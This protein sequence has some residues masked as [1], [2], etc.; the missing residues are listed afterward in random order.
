[1][2]TR[3][4]IRRSSWLYKLRTRV[5]TRKIIP[6][7]LVVAGVGFL[8]IAGTVLWW[9]RD[10]PDPQKIEESRLEESTKIY[11]STGTH[12]LYEIGEAKRTF[13]S[14]EELSPLLAQATLAAE[15]DQFYEHHGLD[16]LGIIRGVIL[17]PLSGQRAQGGSTITQQLI[18]NSILT[19]ERTI[20]RKAKEAVLAIELEQRFE[21]DEI[22]EMYLN[23]IPY[24]SR[25]YGAE[26][27]A[28]TFFG[29]SARNLS[30]AQATTL[31][32]LPQAPSYYSPYGSHLEDMKARQEHI[33]SRMASL[34]MVTQAEAD[35][36]K[37]EELAFLPAAENITA[38]H[39]VFYVKEQLERE[40][41][42]RVVEQGGLKVLTTLDFR[43]Q[44]IAEETLKAEQESL[45][46]RGAS[47][48]SLVAIH[49]ST[50]DILA[51][52]GSIDYFNE[53]IDGNVN[54]SIRHRSPGSSIKP[55]IYTAAFDKGY[56]P[57]TILVDAVTDFGQGYTPKNYDLS[58]RGP[59]TMRTALSN[60]LNIPAVK[61][62]YLAGVKDATELAQKMGMESLNDPDRYGLSLVLGGGEV[63]LL[64]ITSAYGVFA[65]EGVRHPARAI[66][67]VEDD[68]QAVFDATEEPPKGTQV[69]SEQVSRITTD[70]IS[71]NNARALVFGTRSSLQLGSRP[72]AA[73]TG[74]TQDFRDGWTIGFTPS[75]VAGV[76]V[77][78]ND[79]SPMS[80]GSDG[81]TT[82][83]RLWN[84]F[85]RQA[86]DGT[87]IEQFTKPTPI[88][89]ITHGILRGQ[90]KEAKGK[91]VDETS[92]FYTADCPIAEG[93][94]R[95]FK[96]LRSILFYVQRTNPQGTPP[97]RAEADS[98]FTNW[99][100]GI[101]AWRDKHN[102]KNRTNAEEVLYFDS[103]PE[104]SC[105]VGD[106][107]D[108]PKVSIVEPNTTILR[109]SPTDITVEVDS[110]HKL[111]EVRF[112]LDNQEIARKGPDGAHTA[113]ITFDSNFSGRKTLLVLAITENNLIGRAHRTFI[114]NPDDSAPAVTFHTPQNNVTLSALD[115]PYT[116][117]VTAKDSSGID[118]V[119]V[120]YTKE[121]QS[122]TQRIG[123]T[124][125]KASTAADRYEVTWNDA[126]GPGTYTVYAVA[127]DTT[128]NFTESDR[129]TVTIK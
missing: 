22:L 52:A 94:N 64:D 127:Y 112:L 48:G 8:F 44:Q 39:F 58:E 103:L 66:L 38:P 43:L 54:V 34:G 91:W 122:G 99:E 63:R 126:P 14:I 78:N 4:Y 72:V 19:S 79:N 82:A 2:A 12:L 111:R 35:A 81:G 65:A 55:F 125:T 61:T 21:K 119:D 24:G 50:G 83:A 56:T 42:E 106:P 73:K 17:K 18:K 109:D 116:A 70:V 71:D 98:Q 76:W 101:A 105:D 89:D 16:F 110:P 7:L 3:R 1:M 20:Q 107:E 104:P 74:T 15:D 88:T 9:S 95:T 32:A 31:A 36:A 26:A 113:T 40:Y 114:I 59:V 117:K 121:G 92:T 124:S 123:R 129:H 118:F 41:G 100:A 10:L 27:A 90:L 96:E 67:K 75:L 47:N 25:T 97:A 49:P 87:P 85:M 69:L 68:G 77:G 86:L 13:I 51:M 6:R 108:L 23:A 80:Q 37:A 120:L 45:K 60:S 33:L 115:F 84:S 11:D 62:L 128:G 28:Q 46:S 53:E 5:F 57:E 29:T 93:Q 30:L 102:E